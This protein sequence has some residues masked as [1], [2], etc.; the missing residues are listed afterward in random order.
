MIQLL[1]NLIV[2]YHVWLTL[3]DMEK[4]Y[5]IIYSP[6]KY[7]VFIFTK[8]SIYVRR[9]VDLSFINYKVEVESCVG[10]MMS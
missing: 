7:T 5:K 2:L 1:L 3:G 10:R 4:Y 8:A 6:N 9:Y